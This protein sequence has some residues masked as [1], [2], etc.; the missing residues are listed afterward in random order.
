[1]F[2]IHSG[3]LFFGNDLSAHI[4][5]RADDPMSVLP[6][7]CDVRMDVADNVQV[8]QTILYHLNMDHAVAEIKAMDRLQ[9][10]S[11]Y[12]Q[13]W[14]QGRMSA[15][16]SMMDMWGPVRDGGMQPEFFADK[17]AWRAWLQVAHEVVMDWDGFDTWDWDGFTDARTIGINGLLKADFYKFAL[18]LIV[19]FMRTFITR[20]GYYPS[21]MLYPPILA[22]AR[23]EAHKKKFA[24]GLL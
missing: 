12:E 22:G 16:H 23:C 7:H 20:L 3:P 15:I 24:T 13:R 17:K 18:C 4:A 1:M 2:W 5:A 19:F 8:H 21:P 9:F 6:C 10:P 14:N 11:D